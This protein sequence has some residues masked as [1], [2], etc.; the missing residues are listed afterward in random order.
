MKLEEVKMWLE[1][2]PAGTTVDTWPDAF[3]GQRSTTLLHVIQRRKRHDER[4]ALI[5][6]VRTFDHEDLLGE[7]PPEFVLAQ[8]FTNGANIRAAIQ[9]SRLSWPLPD[10]KKL[11]VEDLLAQLANMSVH[12]DC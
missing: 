2:L 11:T 1:R 12:A 7:P 3:P 4:E 9:F 10:E 8:I 5:V 6:H